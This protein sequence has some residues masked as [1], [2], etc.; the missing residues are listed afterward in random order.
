MSVTRAEKETQVEE[1]VVAFRSAQGAV[2]VDYRGLNVPEV[3]DLR[4][5]I[6]AARGQYHVVK[7][8]PALRAIAGTALESVKPLFA[9]PTAVA[10]STGDPV[11]LARTLTAF[12]KNVPKLTIKGGLLQGKSIAPAEVT[13][14]ATLPSRDELLSK[15]LFL[16]QAPMTRLL[17]VLNAAPRDLVSVLSQLEKKKTE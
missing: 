17:G 15:V 4:R 14:L 5:Q 2:F 10:L 9:G 1:L 3:T 12:A 6:R 7:T 8:T 13:A 11:A 16:L